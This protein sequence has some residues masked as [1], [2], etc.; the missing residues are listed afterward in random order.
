M[1]ALRVEQL[2][3]GYAGCALRDIETPKPGPGEVLVP[4]L[5]WVSDV[6]AVLHAGL[7]PVFVD[8]DPGTLGMDNDQV[9]AQLG[10][11]TRAIIVSSPANPT[12]AIQSAETLAELAAL[13]VPLVSDEIYDGLLYDGARTRSALTLDADVFVLDGGTD[14]IN[15]FTPGFDSLN[16]DS[17]AFTALEQGPLQSSAFESGAGL[18]TASTVNVRLIYDATSGALYYDADGSGV[19]STPIQIASLIGAPTLT[20]GDI[21]VDIPFSP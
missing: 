11:R 4:T 19:G 13:G 17:T 16:V 20:A 15:D 14:Q 7:E 8:I 6:T 1:R 5:T 9:I 18:S 2:A 3:A 10:P 21:F 12:G